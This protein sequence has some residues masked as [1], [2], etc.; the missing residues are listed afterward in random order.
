MNTSTPL[1]NYDVLHASTQHATKIKLCGDSF[2]SVPRSVVIDGIV[3]YGG[4]TGIGVDL[5][6]KAFSE[7]YERNHL[8]THVD[9]TKR[10]PLAEVKPQ[11][12]Q[13]KLLNW[14]WQNRNLTNK[15]LT[16]QQILDH[17][18]SWTQVTNLFD[19]KPYD[20]FYNGVCLN[21]DKRDSAILN[22]TDSCGCSA[23]PD[24]QAAIYNSMMEFIE[25][26]ALL[27]SWMTQTFRYQINPQLLK[28]VTPYATLVDKLLTHG[29]MYIFENGV[30]L[31][32]HT[33]VMYYFAKS[34]RDSVQYTIGSSSGLTLQEALTSALVELYQCYA[35]LYNTES[36]AGLENKA[37][38]AYHLK[39]QQCNHQGTRDIIPFMQQASDNYK[40]NSLD[41][42]LAADIYT[43]EQVKHQ[44]Q[45]FSSDIYYYHH[46]E[47]ALDLHFT[48]LFGLDYFFHMSLHAINFDNAFAK[49]AGITRE[50]AYTHPIP[51]P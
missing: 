39:F 27:T 32:G 34:P 38:S 25:R 37:G 41:D 1:P 47:Q 44:L 13:T 48:K 45:Q 6:I 12:Y 14:C 16:P 26:Q 35:Y 33:V 5:P 31:P 19:E 17:E 46:Y 11:E 28:K 50:N 23:H 40:I 9:L 36:S 24:K 30:N 10:M 49:Q 21:G 8:F 22:F 15:K 42:I 51:F 3:S 18:F 2:N 7:Y 43:F 29:E 4:S 20:F